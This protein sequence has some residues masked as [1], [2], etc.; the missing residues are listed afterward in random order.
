MDGQNYDPQD[1]ASIVVARGKY[2]KEK[3]KTEMRRCYFSG[4]DR[5]VKILTAVVHLGVLFTFITSWRAN[6]IISHRCATSNSTYIG[7]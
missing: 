5:D 4:R 7:L 1:R 3:L 2:F 6:V